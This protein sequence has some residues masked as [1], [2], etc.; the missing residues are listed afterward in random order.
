MNVVL[1]YVLSQYQFRIGGGGGGAHFGI[2]V[3]YKD[4]LPKIPEKELLGLSPN[5]HIHVYMSNNGSA[6]SAAGKYVDRSWE[7][8]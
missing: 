8:T 2:C 3:H 5:F 1:F 7:Y 6:Y 4:T